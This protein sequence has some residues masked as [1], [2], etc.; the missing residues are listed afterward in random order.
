[1][2]AMVPVIQAGV[3]AV[4]GIII[5]YL[6]QTKLNDASLAPS[7]EEGYK[8]LC[9]GLAVGFSCVTSGYGM[10]KFLKQLNN[11]NNWYF[12]RRGQKDETENASRKMSFVTFV[13]C[14]IF[15]EA[16]GLY[17]LIVALFLVGY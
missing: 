1:M 14:L 8:Y 3:L 4:Y 9:A 17:G 7:L 6:L 15:L 12:V 2:M 5:S 11:D 13:L 16:I 10:G